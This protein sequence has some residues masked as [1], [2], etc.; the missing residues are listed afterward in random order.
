LEYIDDIKDELNKHNM[1]I[2][3]NYGNIS[4]DKAMRLLIRTFD[5]LR[6][7]LL[8]KKKKINS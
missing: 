5:D 4:Y 1:K 2:I 3:K 6:D 8:S 7:G